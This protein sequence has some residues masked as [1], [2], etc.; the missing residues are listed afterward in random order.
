MEIG[1]KEVLYLCDFIALVRQA[2]GQRGEMSKEGLVLD[3]V[4][5]LV[6]HPIFFY[7]NIIRM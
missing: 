2:D 1:A 5:I 4:L 7:Y 6:R 3:Y